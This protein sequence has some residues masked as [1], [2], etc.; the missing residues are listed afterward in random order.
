MRNDQ[1]AV[2]LWP[3]RSVALATVHST[4]SDARR[5]LG[6]AADGAPLVSS[7]AC[8]RLHEAVISDVDRFDALA[9]SGRPD[10]LL[11]AVELLR[12]R[13]FSGMRRADWAVLD[14]TQ[15]QV[16]AKVVR[17]VLRG[18][19]DLL[20]HARP[21]ESES[22]VRRGLVVAPYDERLYRALLRALAAQGNRVRLRGAMAEL[23]TVAADA[24]LPA[25]PGRWSG[26]EMGMLH[27]ET[28]SLYQEL[29]CGWPATGEAPARL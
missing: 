13:L 17:A 2:A 19:D 1:W 10:R 23:L 9:H 14:G 8:L 16:E 24:P 6:H 25:P 15:A 29:L 4:A 18:A 3:D 22:I 11:E 5:A 7:G 27:P 26:A 28:T 21:A 12:G 20:R